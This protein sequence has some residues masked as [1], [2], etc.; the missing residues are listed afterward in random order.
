[1]LS[2]LSSFT[3]TKIP[4][5]HTSNQDRSAHRCVSRTGAW[6]SHFRLETNEMKFAKKLSLLLSLA[7]AMALSAHAQDAQA[8]FTLPHDA[9]IGAA[10]LPAGQYTVTLYFEGITKAI[11]VPA[12]RKASTAMIV[13]PVS[14]DDFA[15]CKQ[16]RSACSVMAPTGMCVPSALPDRSSHCT[17]PLRRRR[18]RWPALH[19]RR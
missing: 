8:K 12:N 16:L 7:A 5:L 1:M 13:L 17:S 10:V 9:H 4:T 6:Y 19:Q 3:A 14:T 18:L 15:S 2:P 11:I